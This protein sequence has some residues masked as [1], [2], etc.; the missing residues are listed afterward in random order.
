MV[1]FINHDTNN[2]QFI[3]NYD[4]YSMYFRIKYILH[5]L[6][7]LQTR[8]FEIKN[9]KQDTRSNT[10]MISLLNRIFKNDNIRPVTTLAVK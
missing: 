7:L 1:F 10:S 3:Y 5:Y 6:Q 9:I 4:M 2:L 8:I